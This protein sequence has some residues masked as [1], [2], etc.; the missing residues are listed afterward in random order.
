MN[1]CPL[2]IPA[3]RAAHSGRPPGHRPLSPFISCLTS[4]FP[5]CQVSQQLFEDQQHPY[6]PS[7]LLSPLPLPFCQ[8]NQQLF[9]DQQQMLEAE[10]ERLSGLVQVN[11]CGKV[12]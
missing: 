11:K 12:Y 7:N 10:V 3:P 1:L 6:S 5:F 2:I 9:E 8:V 4:T